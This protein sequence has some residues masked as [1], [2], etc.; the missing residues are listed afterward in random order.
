MATEKKPYVQLDESRRSKVPLVLYLTIQP[1]P[2]F[3]M[4]LGMF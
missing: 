2:M 4:D 1:P 3:F